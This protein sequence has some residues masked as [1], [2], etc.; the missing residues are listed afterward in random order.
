VRPGDSDYV[1][2]SCSPHRSWISAS[3]HATKEDHARSNPPARDVKSLPQ[4]LHSF[5]APHHRTD[6]GPRFPLPGPIEDAAVP[7]NRAFGDEIVRVQSQAGLSDRPPVGTSL[8][9]GWTSDRPVR[10]KHAAITRLGSQHGAAAGA[11]IKILACIL[12]HRLTFWRPT[13][14]TG[15]HGHED[16]RICINH[17]RMPA[18]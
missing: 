9:H 5:S 8:L 7:K 14:R 13:G 18:P 15:E 16:H 11:F 2:S 1:G 3:H 10:A 17:G 12:R 6:V 4:L